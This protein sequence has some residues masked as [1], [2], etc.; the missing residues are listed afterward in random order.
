LQYALDGKEIPKSERMKQVQATLHFAT[1][2]AENNR[3]MI[4]AR[5]ATVV[6]IEKPGRA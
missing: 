2:A 1:E 3:P 5:M 6:D 4:C